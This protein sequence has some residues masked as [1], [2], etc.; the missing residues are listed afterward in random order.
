MSNT[1][2]TTLIYGI[3]VDV[4]DYDFS[5]NHD[6][7]LRGVEGEPYAIIYAQDYFIFGIW[8]ASVSD[9]CD[10]CVKVDIDKYPKEEVQSKFKSVFPERSETEVCMYLAQITEW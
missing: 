2:N 10:T 6:R 1:T 3:R 5:D 4:E 8:I 7:Y 9:T